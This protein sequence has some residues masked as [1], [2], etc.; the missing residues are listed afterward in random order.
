MDVRCMRS[1]PKETR[2]DWLVPGLAMGIS[3]GK[4][5]AK[6]QDAGLARMAARLGQRGQR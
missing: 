6:A 4:W 1:L 3:S 2:R 5:A